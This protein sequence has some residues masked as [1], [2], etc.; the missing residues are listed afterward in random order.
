MKSR[1]DK[2]AL[3]VYL[4]LTFILSSGF[5][6]LIIRS[7]HI[8]GGG[9]AYVTALMWCPAMAALLTCKY[10]GRGT[11]TLGWKWG[12]N[13]Y[14]V[15]SYLIPVAYCT[16]TYVIVWTTGLGGFYN[17]TFVAEFAKGFGLGPMPLG[18]LLASIWF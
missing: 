6:F 17:T 13:R 4:I 3:P 10:L 7:G 9:G 5:Y 2:L 16:A 8:L 12:N 11:R 15:W 1:S 14:H 18:L